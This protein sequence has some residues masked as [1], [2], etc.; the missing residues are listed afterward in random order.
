MLGIGENHVRR[1]F[2]VIN[3]WNS[4][5]GSK[6]EIRVLEYEAGKSELKGEP[7]SQFYGRNWR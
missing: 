5:N 3:K 7:I 6:G 2:F 4:G 1:G